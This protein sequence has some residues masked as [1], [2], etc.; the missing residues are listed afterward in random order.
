MINS[1]ISLFDVIGNELYQDFSEVDTSV[2]SLDERLANIYETYGLADLDDLLQLFENDLITIKS[3]KKRGAK[4]K[5][6]S[7]L[8]AL[9]MLEVFILNTKNGCTN[10]SECC[11]MLVQSKYWKSK[12]VASDAA[13]YADHSDALRKQ[14]TIAKGDVESVEIFN[15]HLTYIGTLDTSMDIIDYFKKLRTF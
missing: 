4:K 15:E 3:I 5:W 2:K 14:H 1:N 12:L 8:R 6:T 7:Q 10:D 9:L 11:R 13:Y